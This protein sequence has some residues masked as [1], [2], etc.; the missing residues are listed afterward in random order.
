MLNCSRRLSP[1]ATCAPCS[2]VRP[3]KTDANAPSPV[4]K[5]TFRYSTTCVSR[6]ARPIRNVSTM[7]AR[8]ALALAALDRLQRPVH[9]EARGHEDRR[10]D[11]GHEDREVVGLRRPLGRRARID[12]ANEEVRSEERPEEHDLRADE[13]EHPERPR[14]DAGALVRR[15]RAVMLVVPVQRLGVRRH[16]EASTRSSTT[17]W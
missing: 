13:Q 16:A 17:T 15:R 12:D 7:P 10:V 5:P 11:S 3:K 9:R 14:I 1:M 6:N 2:P 8:K 4:L